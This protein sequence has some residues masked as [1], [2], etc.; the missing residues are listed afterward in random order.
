MPTLDRTRALMADLAKVIGLDELPPD[1]SGGYHLAVAGGTDIFVYG[2]ADE[3][4]LVVALVATLPRSIDYGLALYLLRANM[5]NADT[6]PFQVAA[7][8]QGALIFWGRLRIA[9]FNGASLSALID[10]LAERIGEFRSEIEGA[11]EST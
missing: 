1:D 8:P 10:A 5:F 7:D 4:I 6:A 11:T 3:T 9:E 2:G